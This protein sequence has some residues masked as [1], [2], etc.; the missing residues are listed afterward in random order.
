M[1][2]NIAIENVNN[3]V[4]NANEAKLFNNREDMKQI[5][6]AA[7]MKLQAVEEARK[8][9]M[10]KRL[11]LANNADE[12]ANIKKS[13]EINVRKAER[14]Y[15]EAL[16]K[17]ECPTAQVEFWQVTDE[18][19]ERMTIAKQKTEIIIATSD[20]SMAVA[21][22]N[23]EMGKE[24]ITNDKLEKAPLFVTEAKLFYEAGIMLKDLNGNIV[25]KDTPNVY[26]PVDTANGYWQWATYHEYNLNA[27]IKEEEP[28]TI[29]NVRIKEFASLQEFALYRGVNN[30]LSRG[31]NGLEKAGNA[32][33]ATQHE[34]FNKVFQK[35]IELKAN[36]SV[37][38]K[39]YNLGK[40]IKPKV[41]NSATLGV[42]VEKFPEYDLEIGDRIITILNEKKFDSKT[43]K[44]RYMIDAITK[45]ANCTPQG[46]EKKIGIEEVLAVLDSLSAEKVKYLCEITSNQ[47]DD[48]YAALFTQYLENHGAKIDGQAA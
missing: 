2:Q 40:T 28:L 5:N 43:I 38:T 36:I 44:K 12:E 24:L 46:Q 4:A 11:F 20:Y 1:A 37:V 16:K 25:A 34:F 42:I 19:A 45:L 17:L 32:A 31:F 48:I 3:Q 39:Y 27:I 47:V 22:T 6:E 15:F 26:V 8:N 35:A 14:E 23:V 30:V 10:E 21:K 9:L 41:W 29:E 33:L 7:A 13:A 18:T